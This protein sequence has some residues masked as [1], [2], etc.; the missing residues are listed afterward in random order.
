MNLQRTT[1]QQDTHKAPHPSHHLE[2]RDSGLYLIG[3]FKLA[4]AIFFLGVSLGA[5]HFIHHDLANAVDRIF[6][7][8]HFDPESRVVDFITD[9]VA[10]V[11]HRKLR[12]ISLGS[13]L[14][15]MLC[16]TEAYGLLR[17]RV[18][19]EFVTLWLSVSFLPW[20]SFEIYRAP[21]LWHISILLVNL[22]VVAY[23][24]WMLQRKK[25]RKETV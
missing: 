21:S 13:V 19:A 23:L 5:L 24:V 20:E 18:W 12:L 17:R 2:A 10:L 8:L 25:R 16:C 15:A 3:L 9:K 6:R 4:K 7:E 14:Y 11:T 22:A 1:V